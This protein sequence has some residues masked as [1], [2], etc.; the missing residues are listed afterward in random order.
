V[1]RLS[2]LALTLWLV[3]PSV[4]LASSTEGAV[5]EFNPEEDFDLG[6][7]IPIHLG[8]LDLSI[9]KAVA[10]LIL[11]TLVTI[12]LGI[13]LM[14]A[15]IGAKDEVGR[16]QAVGEM[17]YE[18]AQTQVAEQGLPTK[19]IGMWFP[20]VASLMLF[21]WVIN[22]LGFIPL[23]LSNDRVDI[24]GVELPTLAIYAATSSISVTLALALMTWVFTHIEGIRVNGPVKYFKSWMPSGM[25]KFSVVMAVPLT[26]LYLLEVLGQLMR[27]VSLSVRLY[28]NMLAGHMLILT[29]IGLIFVLENLAVAVFAVPFAAAFYL[30]EVVIVVSIQA[31]IFAALSAIYIGSAIEPEH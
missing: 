23:P 3:L 28:A 20:Y 19:A 29:F 12:A 31:Y 26:L 7:W 21:I 4:A 14:R 6:E 2:A 10:Y 27:L 9:N 25:P 30:F 17:V 8:P 5:E 15:R 24:F 18:I 13:F 11:G 22:M 16:R 1:K